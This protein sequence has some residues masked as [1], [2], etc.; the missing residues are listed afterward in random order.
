MTKRSEKE[1]VII[2]KYKGN[3]VKSDENGALKI[4]NKPL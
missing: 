1:E 4:G 3:E 2:R